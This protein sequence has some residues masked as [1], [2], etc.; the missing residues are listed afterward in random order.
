M[1]RSSFI[2]GS[3]KIPCSVSSA[4]RWTN[5]DSTSRPSSA[6]AI[7]TSS[8]LLPALL[9]IGRLLPSSSRPGRCDSSRSSTS[10]HRLHALQ[11]RI[12]IQL[13]RIRNP[14]LCH[15]RH[16]LLH[17]ALR[18]SWCRS[19][20]SR[21]PLLPDRSIAR[22][23]TTTTGRRHARHPRHGRQSGKCGHT[24]THEHLI[25]LCVLVLLLLFA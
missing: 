18:R 16:H 15:H 13:R 3:P 23:A 21:C 6:A 25:D 7:S 11:K 4:R 5:F 20:S 9:T 19:D 2:L 17:H 22:T 8:S 10:L 12:P 14:L 1:N 24:L